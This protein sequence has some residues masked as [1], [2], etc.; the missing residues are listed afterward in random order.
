MKK[1]YFIFLLAFLVFHLNAFLTFNALAGVY[2]ISKP[3]T[4]YD[5]IVKKYEKPCQATGY[6]F[7][8]LNC[9]TN[10][11]LSVKCPDGD[12]YRLCSCD[13]E[14]LKYNAT[15]CVDE[16]SGV[17]KLLSGISCDENGVSYYEKCTCPE[18]YSLSC[19]GDFVPRNKVDY[20]D[21]K[22]SLCVCDPN[23]FFK[24]DNGPE[25]NA[26]ECFDEINGTMYSNCK[27]KKVGCG[28]G[29]VSLETYWCNQALKCFIPSL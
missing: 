29:E 3:D 11:K 8:T 10:K 23:K 18:E 26:K 22:Y 12:F 17:K 9:P 7:S 6:F 21:N 1:S 25:V 20:C 27:A 16:T 5:Y 2:F 13:L 15:N 19:T 24:C 28:D 14:T 4:N